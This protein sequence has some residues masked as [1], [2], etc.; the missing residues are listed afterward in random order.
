M[1]F[2]R[3]THPPTHPP[4]STYRYMRFTVAKI[5]NSQHNAGATKLPL[6]VVIQ[7]MAL[8]V[9][10]EETIDVVNFGA[11]VR[12]HPPT[13]PLTHSFFQYT[14]CLALFTHI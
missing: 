12:V 1:L 2:D 13:H 5:P 8:D 7:P 14:P 6:G 9:T 10:G 11:T 3:L 4:T